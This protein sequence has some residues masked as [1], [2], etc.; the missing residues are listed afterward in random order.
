[1]NI[2]VILWIQGEKITENPPFGDAF[3]E[4]IVIVM[5]KSFVFI[6]LYF[7]VLSYLNVDNSKF[8]LAV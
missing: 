6:L 4:G 1:M 2:V 7:N 8:Y 3:F 5:K